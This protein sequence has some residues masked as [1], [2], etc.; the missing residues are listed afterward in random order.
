[1]KKQIILAAFAALSLCMTACGNNAA[2]T[3]NAA[4]SPVAMT[5]MTTAAATTASVTETTVLTTTAAA[6]SSAMHSSA[7]QTTAATTRATVSTAA[8]TSTASAAKTTAAA[9]ASAKPNAYGYYAFT[10]KPREGTAYISVKDLEG[11]WESDNTFI[12]FFNCDMYSGIFN[13][14][15]ADN[16]LTVGNVKLEYSLK[17]DNNGKQLWYNLYDVDGK[18]VTGFEANGDIPVDEIYNTQTNAPHFTRFLGTM[19][20]ISTRQGMKPEDYVGVW[21]V[22]RY[23]IT[24]ELKDQVYDINVKLNTSAAES[25]S[26]SYSGYYDPK[27]A[28]I[29]CNGTGDRSHL[30]CSEDG[31]MNANLEKEG[32]TAIFVMREGMLKWIDE[33][34][35][36]ADDM[37]FMPIN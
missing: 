8:A 6:E 28:I 15:N 22:A 17:A 10:E 4:A 3:Q 9:Q 31:T 24:I 5:E 26:W 16:T 27:Q 21:S 13:M 12:K 33:D 19:D 25:T 14:Y 11:N 32:E 23:Y 30:V 18:F 2:T 35:H 7:A 36:E 37:E 1:M 34:D 20:Y 29:V